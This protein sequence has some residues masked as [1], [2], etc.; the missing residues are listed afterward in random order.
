V[1]KFSENS[2]TGVHCPEIEIHP[3]IDKPK[4][5]LVDKFL[6]ILNKNNNPQK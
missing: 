3:A 2:L 6:I 4:K 1:S 5:S